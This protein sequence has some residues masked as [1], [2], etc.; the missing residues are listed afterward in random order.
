[1]NVR[2]RKAHFTAKNVFFFVETTM[3]HRI[4]FEN[5]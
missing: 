4:P 5:I 1:M 3:D 2:G